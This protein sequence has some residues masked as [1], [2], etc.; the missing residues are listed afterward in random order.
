MHHDISYLVL[1]LHA[2][3][4]FFIVLFFVHVLL[5]TGAIYYAMTHLY[6]KRPLV[7]PEGL[8]QWP[9]VSIIKPLTTIDSSIYSNL[10]TYFTM[11]YPTIEIF[12]CFQDVDEKTLESIKNLKK[13][14]PSVPCHIIISD[15][16]VGV[17]PKINNMNIAYQK[18]KYN[19]LLISDCGI[20]T[21]STALKDM[22]MTFYE[23]DRVGMVHQVP[24]IVQRPGFVHTM[25]TVY[26][27]TWHAKLYIGASFFGFTCTSG[28]SCLMRKDVIDE[29]GGLASFGPYLAEDYFLAKHFFKNGWRIL[30][31][32]QPALQNP[33][34]YTVKAFQ[35]RT[36]RWYKLRTAMLPHTIILEPL[37]ECVS[38]SLL[39]AF[40]FS[41]N[42]KCVSFWAFFFCH[43]LVWLLLD[44][45]LLQIMCRT[46]ELMFTKFDFFWAWLSLVLSSIYLQI[47]SI[48]KPTIVWRRRTYRVKWGGFSEE[49][50]SD[51]LTHVSVLKA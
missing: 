12:L 22:V 49:I 45:V 36:M 29:A 17:N 24:W 32:H 39:F 10:E 40:G 20:Q 5:H 14:Y 35:E 3:A 51:N 11:D 2:A 47:K 18:A 38:A 6:K 16:T 7:I 33:G 21:E 34:S 25:Q 44:Y 31:S 9:G 4:T 15:C 28:M 23:N 41:Y 26:F 30:I 27:G 43:C 1:F 50:I 46:A 42:F 37:S 8:S 13:K 48:F 19:L